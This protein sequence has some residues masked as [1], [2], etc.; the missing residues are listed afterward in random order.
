MVYIWWT[1]IHLFTLVEALSW[2][3]T[4][5]QTHL[6]PGEPSWSDQLFWW[7]FSSPELLGHPPQ[8]LSVV[9]WVF[10]GCWVHQC[11][12]LL[13]MSQTVDLGMP[14]VFVTVCL[15]LVWLIFQLNDGLL[16]WHLWISYWKFTATDSKCTFH[17]SNEL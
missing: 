14:T 17:T 16:Q 3:L 8:S 5:A 15:W 12:L 2:L 4:L 9:F 10:W 13:R 7:A 6:S 1:L 11:I